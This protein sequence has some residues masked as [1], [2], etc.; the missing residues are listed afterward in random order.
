MQLEI[1]LRYSI[2]AAFI[3]FRGIS[4]SFRY[5]S[6]VLMLWPPSSP[7]SYRLTFSRVASVMEFPAQLE[8]LYR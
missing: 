8:L 5:I 7:V 2:T 4:Q 3:S 6:Q 1:L